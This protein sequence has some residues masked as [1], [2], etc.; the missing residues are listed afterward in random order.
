MREIKISET[1]SDIPPS[2]INLNARLFHEKKI[3]YFTTKREFMVKKCL[4]A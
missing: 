3:I 4:F 2:K 1:F